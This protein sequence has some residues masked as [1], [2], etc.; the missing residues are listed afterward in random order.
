M[1]LG[2]RTQEEIM[3]VRLK[4]QREEARKEAREEV[5]TSMI[6]DGIEPERA[7]RLA[8]VPMERAKELAAGLNC[9]V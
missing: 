2:G 5:F 8:K 9:H 1:I 7:A 4:C 6:L 3:Q